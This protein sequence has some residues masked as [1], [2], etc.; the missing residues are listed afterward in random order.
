MLKRT[1]ISGFDDE[2]TASA[3]ARGEGK[4][5][6]VE[7]S[8]DDH[9]NGDDNEQ[10]I[11]KGEEEEGGVD[12]SICALWD[13]VVSVD[14]S[15]A[16][17]DA[18]ADVDADA[19]LAEMDGFD[20]ST[21]D[22]SGAHD[23]IPFT[24]A[25]SEKGCGQDDGDGDCDGDTASSDARRN[26]DFRLKIVPTALMQLIESVPGSRGSPTD[27]P[28][29]KQEGG[30]LVLEDDF[31]E[32]SR[33]VACKYHETC[34]AAQEAIRVA[35]EKRL[36]Q[37][38]LLVSSNGDNSSSET[39]P[40]LEEIAGHLELRAERLSQ[41]S[42]SPGS[43]TTTNN[44]GSPADSRGGLDFN[45]WMG[46]RS[47]A[48]LLK[49]LR[50][51]G[52]DQAGNPAAPIVTRVC[53]AIMKQVVLL[54]DQQLEKEGLES[55]GLLVKNLYPMVAYRG[56]QMRL[57]F[58][59]IAELVLRHIKAHP[60]PRRLWGWEQ[61]SR[62]IDLGRRHRWYFKAYLVEGAGTQRCNGIYRVSAEDAAN[63]HHR[64][65]RLRRSLGAPT[66]YSQSEE[67]CFVR[68]KQYK[69]LST[70]AFWW[71][72]S[73]P[74]PARPGLEGDVKYYCRK[75]KPAENCMPPRASGWL[76]RDAGCG[77]SPT[78]TPLVSE[79]YLC[80]PGQEYDTLEWDL[81]NWLIDN[82]VVEEIFRERT[83]RDVVLHSGKLL[84]FLC[85][86]EDKLTPE[87]VDLI[88]RSCVREPS[89]E[90]QGPVYKVLV[91]LVKNMNL[92]LV[93]HLVGRLQE[94]V[95]GNAD[96]GGLNHVMAFLG[97]LAT[98]EDH[99]VI[100]RNKAVRSALAQL[101]WALLMRPSVLKHTSC[102]LVSKLLASVSYRPPPT[103]KRDGIV[104]HGTFLERCVVR[105]QEQ[106]LANDAEASRSIAAVHHMLENFELKHV[107]EMAQLLYGLPREPDAQ[108]Q[109]I[110]FIAE[111]RS[112][113]ECY[114][115]SEP[116]LNN[117]RNSTFGVVSW[118]CRC[119]VARK[120]HSACIFSKI[121]HGQ[122][123]C[124]MCHTPMS[125][126]KTSGDGQEVTIRVHALCR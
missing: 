117:I 88:W 33:R 40:L 32:E 98:D 45:P 87:H 37:Y 83:H 121:C 60:L 38:M 49:S 11:E 78:V 24:F 103:W 63:A 48:D 5:R 96:W 16:S 102:K 35:Q 57:V 30:R 23:S 120:A 94:A 101:V 18:D 41:A 14:G 31:D 29:G 69:M 59:F 62:L 7:L 73:E 22:S 114:I 8:D 70:Q 79:G 2:S 15:G 43:T 106:S 109:V 36:R 66:Y 12:D 67:G 84:Q 20:L 21:S 118:S 104:D 46:L 52:A 64:T 72:I 92:R 55:L 111:S 99:V 115:C 17:A 39:G 19:A 58:E 42:S 25:A 68:M 51:S 44:S 28:E 90:L 82:K 124:D 80:P 3:C 85:G 71:F 86:M 50:E 9:D 113:A 100:A 13:L 110:K 116:L 97:Y 65:P 4:R 26:Q 74:D 126:A 53:R 54:G 112:F 6:R 56:D 108:S 125:F 34:L 93:V 76:K 122:P 105:W 119:V 89:A 75:S 107:Q 95:D 91:V 1:S 77:Q 81:A 47:L 61:A 27:V 123:N 10:A